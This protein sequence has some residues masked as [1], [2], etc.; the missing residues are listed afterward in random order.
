MEPLRPLL[1]GRAELVF[2]DRPGHGWSERGSGNE[3]PSGQARTLAALLDRLGIKQA[4]LVAHSFG[5]AVEV[6]F[7]LDYPE[8]VKGLVFLSPA[9]HPAGWQDVLRHEP[10]TVPVAGWLFSEVL[11]GRPV[12][13]G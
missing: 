8:R 6:A 11:R 4:I 13:R 2:F 5:G 10:T 3:T 12:C 7:A 9:T 1:E